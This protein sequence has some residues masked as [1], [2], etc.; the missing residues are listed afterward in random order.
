MNAAALTKSAQRPFRPRERGIMI[1]EQP[2]QEQ[3]EQP[4]AKASD[5][6][7]DPEIRRKRNKPMKKAPAQPSAELPLCSIRKPL[8]EEQKIE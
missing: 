3:Q 1:R 2:P 8:L 7:E 5:K 6:D 4:E